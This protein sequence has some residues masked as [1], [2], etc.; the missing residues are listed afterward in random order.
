[1]SGKAIHII[2]AEAESECLQMQE[3]IRETWPLMPRPLRAYNKAFS[4]RWARHIL[5]KDA[6]IEHELMAPWQDMADEQA[7]KWPRLREL[8]RPPVFYYRWGVADMDRETDISALRKAIRIA[9]SVNEVI[10]REGVS[11][12]P[13]DWWKKHLELMA[14][15]DV[16]AELDRLGGG[17]QPRPNSLCHRL[18]NGD[19]STVYLA[20]IVCHNIM[21][22]QSQAALL[23][24]PGEVTSGW[25]G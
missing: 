25:L 16:I 1:M 22:L 20:A 9:S 13:H 11:D 15:P 8:V 17:E 21:D 23:L 7:L 10:S 14:R 18:P 3:V 5:G 24:W 6:S 19:W 2:Q 12:G 4:Q